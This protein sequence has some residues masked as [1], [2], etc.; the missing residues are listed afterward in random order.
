MFRQETIQKKSKNKKKRTV[1]EEKERLRNKDKN[2]KRKHLVCFR[3]TEE[4]KDLINEKVK[5]SGR[6]KQEYLIEAVL[7]HEVIFVGDRRVFNVMMGILKD[8]KVELKEIEETSEVNE[9]DIYLLKTTIKM[10]ENLFEK[11]RKF[12]IGRASCRERV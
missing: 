9:N 8:I 2:R 3:V 5:L 10:M 11:E 7:N 4:E 12:Q 6:L 1:E